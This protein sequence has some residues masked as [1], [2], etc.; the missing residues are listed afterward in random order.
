MT[1]TEKV[2]KDDG[3]ILVLPVKV[4]FLRACLVVACFV[5]FEQVGSEKSLCELFGAM[6]G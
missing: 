1:L 6:R 5:Q 3:G 4:V 2:F